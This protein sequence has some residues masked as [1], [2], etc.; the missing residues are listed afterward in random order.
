ML[1]IVAAPSGPIALGTDTPAAIRLLPGGSGANTA[2]WL[3]HFGN[4]V[5]FA[6]R[7]GR[8]TWTD[9]AAELRAHGVEPHLAS[10]GESRTGVLVTLIGPAGERSFLTDRGAN[11]RLAHG[12]LPAALLDGIDHLHVSGYAFVGAG[13]RAGVRALLD[14]AQRRGVAFSVDGG[15]AAFLRAA[16]TDVFFGASHGAAMCFANADEAAVLTGETGRAKQ[17]A[18]LAS[19]YGAAIVT[20]GPNGACAA[21]GGE[22]PITAEPGAPVEAL[23]TSGAG[24]AFVAGFLTARLSGASLEQALRAGIRAGTGAVLHYGGRPPLRAA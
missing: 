15:S 17:A 2:A 9:D 8:A 12:D 4:R 5:R 3:S 18:A 14:A 13:P 22:A 16:G 19:R 10:D 11:A 23:D 24:D 7:V 21:A 20:H 1:D 6:G